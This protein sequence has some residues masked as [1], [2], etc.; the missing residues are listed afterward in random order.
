MMLS[1]Y[2]IPRPSFLTCRK[3]SN[4]AITLSK[5]SYHTVQQQ[6]LKPI[7]DFTGSDSNTEEPIADDG[8]PNFLTTAPV[9]KRQFHTNV[10]FTKTPPF[11]SPFSQKDLDN[12]AKKCE[13]CS[14]LCDFTDTESDVQAK[15]AKTATLKEICDVITESSIVVLTGESIDALFNMFY[16]NLNR[17]IPPV[18]KKYLCYDDEPL[19]YEINWP[20]LSIVYNIIKNYQKLVPNDT[21]YHT[22]RKTLSN[23]LRSAD[24]NERDFILGFF[25]SYVT[26]FPDQLDSVMTDFAYKLV[27]YHEGGLPFVVLPILKFFSEQLKLSKKISPLM[28]KIWSNSILPLISCQHNATIY[29]A[30]LEIVDTM[31]TINPSITKSTLEIALHHWPE[32]RPSKQIS[33]FYLLNS[34]AEKLSLEDF[35]IMCKPLFK[36]YARCATTSQHAKVVETSFQVWANVKILQMIM[37]NT[38]DVFPIV[39]PAYQ[40]IM[41]EHWK[42]A[43]K[44]ASLTAIKQMHDLDPFVFDELTQQAK[45]GSQQE[46]D[47]AQKI[48]KGWALIARTAAKSDKTVNL[49]R[50]LAD[51]QLKFAKV[52]P[53]S[54]TAD[55]RKRSLPSNN[56]M[57]N[58]K[59]VVPKSTSTMR[60]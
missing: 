55:Q 26:N 22:L 10:P 16:A 5:L 33:Y 39:Y 15:P 52:T 54:E 25:T 43:T 56:S 48:H 17:S 19:I 12:F 3:R 14:V 28:E 32:S 36:T 40:R 51:I 42:P 35:S 45:K 37:D 44:N 8:V 57:G 49:A 31:A 50:V 41:K 46:D 20:H 38:H 27:E 29:P 4:N 59:I 30:F 2:S 9:V 53:I 1:R 6:A 18:E 58:P 13:Q 11:G 21:R 47:T 23:L 60:F 34:L 7:T 24:P